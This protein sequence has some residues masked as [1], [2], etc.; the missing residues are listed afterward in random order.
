MEETKNRGVLPEHLR[1]D[2]IYAGGVG[3][4]MPDIMTPAEK[5]LRYRPVFDTQRK[6]GL[7][8]MNCV[9]CSFIVAIEFISRKFGKPLNLSP[10]FLYWA[11]GC[12]PNGNTFGRCYDA[13][14]TTFTC[15]QESWD[16]LV[17]MTRAEFGKEPPED[18]KAEALRIAAEWTLGTLRWV[19][20][21]V[22]AM[23][24][25]LLK[26]P[27]WFCNSNHAMVIY[28]I[29]D[30]IRVFDTEANET[31]GLSSYPLEYVSEIEAIYNIPFTPKGYNA[32]VMPNVKIRDNAQVFEV[33]GAGRCGLK[34]T[35]AK[36][37]EYI[38]VD[39]PAL[40][41]QQFIQRNSREVDGEM[42][43]SSGPTR[44]LKTA[45]FDSFPHATFREFSD[46]NR[47]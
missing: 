7:E 43:F 30:R 32:T 45:D 47:S 24:A 3:D 9:Q 39:Q 1:P 35:S 10:R 26:G 38:V 5:W 13:A 4:D 6:L 19:P 33:E 37:Q 20:A 21:N 25:A 31:D 16:W 40:V 2:R 36:G 14:R 27:L 12:G 46:I 17:A 15:A 22:E 18:V 34:I 41:V 11:S 44:S 23:R 42:T 29:D 8:T 28:D